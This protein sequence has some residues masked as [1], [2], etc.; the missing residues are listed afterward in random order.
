MAQAGVIEPLEF[1]EQPNLKTEGRS[2]C[3]VLSHPSSSENALLSR[4]MLLHSLTAK[5]GTQRQFAAV[6]SLSRSW[7]RA[8]ADRRGES[9]ENDPT[10]L[11]ILSIE[12][13]IPVQHDLPS[14]TPYVYGD[15]FKASSLRIIA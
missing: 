5:F 10:G 15:A 14:I 9:H 7:G 6:C 8:D 1:A 13:V 2:G 3:W 11:F 12:R 4:R